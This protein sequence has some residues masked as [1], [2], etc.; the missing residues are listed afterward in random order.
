MVAVLFIVSMLSLPHGRGAFCLAVGGNNNFQ[1]NYKNAALGSGNFMRVPDLK[2]KNELLTLSATNSVDA[3]DNGKSNGASS[4]APPSVNSIEKTKSKDDDVLSV[5]PCGDELDKRMIKFALPCVANFAINPLVGAVDLFWI[6]RMKNPLAVAGQAAS[7]QVFSSLFWLSSFLP[8]VT[9]TLVAKKKAENDTDGVQTAVCNALFVG[10]I[11]AILSSTLILL[12]PEKVLSIVLKDGAPALEYAKPYLLIRGFAFLPS[13]ISVT[14]YSALR[15]VLDTVT[16][17]KIS[18]F[19]NIFNAI[20]DPLLIFKAGMGVTGAALATLAAEIISAV[21]FMT[22]LLKKGLIRWSKLLRLPDMELLVP[23]L[24]GG[25]ALQLRNFALNLTFIAVTRV[26]QSIDSTGV[27]AAAHALALQT[28][29]IGGVFLLALST[30]AQILIPREMVETVDEKTGE[31]SGGPVAAKAV[32][33]RLMSWGF[34]MGIALGALQIGLL[35]LL[36]KTTPLPEVRKAA[37]VPAYLASF[38]Q[39]INGLVF[40]GEGIM[41]GCGNFLQLSF[42]TTIAT[43]ATIFALNT[44]PYKYGLTGVWMSFGVFNTFRLAGVWL[45]QT[46]LGPLALRNITNR[47]RK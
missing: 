40:I 14:G 39:M 38:Y 20:F 45:H 7:N 23:L 9:A 1:T 15:G 34:I 31:K 10:F 35:P 30:V 36:Q 26:T 42:S 19:A 17:L 5:W 28:F 32:A 29:Q 4:S 11:I 16:P 6:N 46:R 18:I 44:L 43:A 37:L 41:V 8:S 13:L 21:T 33:N 25:A 12:Q 22:V 3:S 24:K 47:S 27:S 2:K